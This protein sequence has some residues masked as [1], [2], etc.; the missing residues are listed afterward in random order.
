MPLTFAAVREKYPQYND[1]PDQE[2]ADKLH[3]KFYAD[4][5]TDQFYAK[6]GY[7]P[8]A[9]AAQA[10]ARPAPAVPSQVGGA[11]EQAIPTMANPL[12][13]SGIAPSSDLADTVS[14]IGT[15]TFRTAV[16]GMRDTGQSLLDLA[17][18]VVTGRANP[19]NGMLEEQMR[20]APDYNA[21]RLGLIP[22]ASP[23]PTEIAEA[24]IPRLVLPQ[25]EQ[26]AQTVNKFGRG[27][28][29]FLSGAEL[30][31][32][33]GAGPVGSGVIGDLLF[34]TEG[35][36]LSTLA[37]QLATPA[38]G[39]PP[40]TG[41][42]IVQAIAKPL[43]IEP[44][45]NDLLSRLKNVAEGGVVGQVL[46]S[47]LHFIGKA[48]GLEPRIAS[49]IRLEDLTPEMTDRAALDPDVQRILAANNIASPEDIAKFADVAKA[50][51]DAKAQA[52]GAR[53]QLIQAAQTG[54]PSEA[55]AIAQGQRPV[56]QS[57]SGRPVLGKPGEPLVADG[58]DLPRPAPD[59][60]AV[61]P[62]GT[63][64]PQIVQDARP[65]IPDAQRAG[66]ATA[67]P[68]AQGIQASLV[69]QF[70]ADSQIAKLRER[71][72]EDPAPLVEKQLGIPADTFRGL[73]MDAKERTVAAAQRQRTAETPGEPLRTGD[74]AASQGAAPYS[75]VSTPQP[76]AVRVPPGGAAEDRGARIQ[77]TD[78]EL[79]AGQTPY[80]RTAAGTSDRPF[81]ARDTGNPTPEQARG[82]E[83]A[84]R[85]KA[86]AARQA[87][88]EDLLRQWKEREN[89]REKS[90]AAPDAEAASK[91]QDAK[92]ST[93]VAAADKDGRFPVDEF[94]YVVSDAGGPVRY[95]D[96]KQAALWAVNV[97]HKKSPDQYFEIA[98]HPSGKGFTVRE[99]GRTEA[100]REDVNAGSRDA[101]GPAAAGGNRGSE[102]AD[103]RSLPPPQVENPA[104][105]VTSQAS[106]ISGRSAGDGE[107]GNAEH[108]GDRG[109][110]GGQPGDAGGSTSQAG[111]DIGGGAESGAG[112]NRGEGEGQSQEGQ[113]QAPGPAAVPEKI[114]PAR[115]VP[116]S[117]AEAER[118]V[119][120]VGTPPEPKLSR[121]ERAEAQ[122]AKDETMGRFGEAHSQAVAQGDAMEKWTTARDAA[123]PLHDYERQGWQ[124]AAAGRDGETHYRDGTVARD[125]FDKGYADGAAWLKDNPKPAANIEVTARTARGAETTYSLEPDAERI[126][127]VA[128]RVN[129]FSLNKFYSNP[130]DPQIYKDLFGPLLGKEAGRW[131]DE[132]AELGRELK[133][134]DLKAPGK[135]FAD[136]ARVLFLSNDGIIRSLAN[137]FGKDGV[138]NAAIEKVADKFFAPVGRADKTGIGMPYGHAV[139]QRV[140]SGLNRLTKLLKPFEDYRLDQQRQVLEQIPRLIVSGKVK[141]GTS[142]VHNIA[143]EIQEILKDWH[144]YAT[145]AGVELGD[146]GPGYFPRELATDRVLSKPTEFLEKARQ[147]YRADGATKEEADALADAWLRRVVESDLGFRSDGNDFVQVPTGKT[148]KNEKAR[149]LS[150][151]ADKIL[152]DFYL[153]NVADV[154]PQYFM[155]LSRRAEWVRR[156][157]A[158]LEQWKAAKKEIQESG[159]GEAIPEMVRAIQSSTGSTPAPTGTAARAALSLA[160]VWGVVGYLARA[161]LSSLTEPVLAA[162]RSGNIFDAFRGYIYTARDIAREISGIKDPASRVQTAREIAEDL[163]LVSQIGDDMIMAQRFGGNAESRLARRITNQFFVRNGLYHFTEA[164]NVAATSIG[165]VFMRRLARSIG[166]DDVYG[167]SSKFLAG[168]LG[169]KDLDGFA[170]W[171]NAHVNGMPGPEALRADS[172]KAAQDYKDAL[173]RFVRQSILKPTGAEKARY[174]NH[175]IGALFYHLQS[176]N[177]SFQKNVFNR[178]GRLG[179]A[180]FRGKGMNALDRMRLMAPIAWFGSVAVPLQ[181]AIGELRDIYQRD[182]AR[183]PNLPPMPELQKWLRALSRAGL[184]TF[185]LP[186]NIL[187]SSKYQRDPTS[188]MQGPILGLLGDAATSLTQLGSKQNSP[189]TNTSERKAAKYLYEVGIKPT[190]ISALSLLPGKVGA[191][192]AVPG[193]QYVALPSTREEKFIAPV[194]GK[195]TGQ[196]GRQSSRQGGREQGGRES[197]R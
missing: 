160:R 67:T 105:N 66:L 80:S 72:G 87:S 68:E 154:L 5:P 36:N 181:Y 70:G 143:G 124:A 82:F 95:K 116:R 49:Q 139:D 46:T 178:F 137:R 81:Q 28:V 27:L 173:F 13:G 42:R 7:S 186:V 35:G 176:Y 118:Y 146:R 69:D 153:R 57:D 170:K 92:F 83:D 60:I 63:A 183:D 62:E 91:Y 133:G 111:G 17:R 44:G 31:G 90:G 32:A 191:A 104:G 15:E 19:I 93:K 52:R 51:I 168:E 106:D 120:K 194:A 172:S 43:A 121:G 110:A 103:T 30:G 145:D 108:D 64:T 21:S 126:L 14:N 148:A 175:P 185:D 192:L 6:I 45:E 142:T 156:M 187:T 151:K 86:E 2:L 3:A 141:V 166:S 179:A 88:T 140:Q 78:T 38:P 195:P 102:S 37:K 26:P 193:I 16:G 180:A 8:S 100:P 4:I 130:L 159:A 169:I 129:K 99:R 167:A 132:F 65:G 196:G 113:G 25:V 58:A 75:P 107:T 54:T 177:Y 53:D 20:P 34:P 188:A 77:P 127:E 76:E 119:K 161:T 190:L 184:G 47:T 114:A 155:R 109:P 96:Q 98:N 10:A 97:G 122:A 150:D 79:A 74:A 39:A 61:S 165:Q 11:P 1:V 73:S 162:T 174:A 85:A 157:G 33:G 152:D 59:V 41:Q 50:R 89:A 22:N 29:S 101:G 189:N 136:F 125:A 131:A 147:A 115:N 134:V 128:A 55:S 48:V 138:P 23:T 40:T 12:A 149:V 135:G 117:P 144:Q 94:G 112:Q 197:R 71:I 9:P 171:V 164:T 158:D 163:G 56:I 123:M 18:N 182:P 24:K 84:A